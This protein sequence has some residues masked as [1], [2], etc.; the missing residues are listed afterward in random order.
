MISIQENNAV[1]H[2]DPYFLS[3]SGSIFAA[4]DHHVF[5]DG[6]DVKFADISK[7]TSFISALNEIGVEFD[8]YY[9]NA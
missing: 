3:Q 5:L 7:S 8:V 9:A 2:F 6:F 4:W 1:I